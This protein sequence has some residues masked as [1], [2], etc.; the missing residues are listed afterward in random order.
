MKHLRRILY[1]AVYIWTMWSIL[2]IPA[3]SAEP[4]NIKPD[5]NIPAETGWII[6]QW[7]PPEGNP[8]KHL[9]LISDLH[10]NSAAQKSHQRILDILTQN[11]EITSVL[12]EGASGRCLTERYRTFEASHREFLIQRFVQLGL[13]T[14][15]EAWAIQSQHD[16]D[17]LGI[18]NPDTYLNHLDVSRRLAGIPQSVFETLDKWIASLKERRNHLYPEEALELSRL[19]E[20]YSRQGDQ[21]DLERL[22][23]LLSLQLAKKAPNIPQYAVIQHAAR[24]F[25]LNA[26]VDKE[27]ALA[28][29]RLVMRKLHPLLS[30]DQKQILKREL[31]TAKNSGMSIHRVLF[32]TAQ[33][34]GLDLTNFPN[35]IEYLDAAHQAQR[36]DTKALTSALKSVDELIEKILLPPG[37]PKQL[38]RTLR[39]TQTLR[40]M[41]GMAASRNATQR[42]R[43]D[44][45]E[46]WPHA[47][48]DALERLSDIE[49]SATDKELIETAWQDAEIFYRLAYRRDVEMAHTAA[50]LSDRHSALILGG[51]HIDGLL[52]ILKEH[53]IAY[54]VI[55]P[56]VADFES[57]ERRYRSLLLGGKPTAEQVLSTKPHSALMLP[58]ATWFDPSGRNP[59]ATDTLN[60]YLKAGAQ[61]QGEPENQTREML[62][63]L[64]AAE[65]TPGGLAA[66][67]SAERPPVP[68]DLV[69]ETLRQWR[70]M[71]PYEKPQRDRATLSNAN[72]VQYYFHDFME[73]TEL[74][75]IDNA[76]EMIRQLGFDA[77]WFNPFFET[78]R[79]YD[80]GGY[81]ISNYVNFHPDLLAKYGEDLL[82]S[83]LKRLQASGIQIM[84][85]LVMNHTSAAHLWYQASANP[86]HP[87]YIQFK[88]HYVWESDPNRYQ[89]R[90]AIEK[91]SRHISQA[92][93]DHLKKSGLLTPDLFNP[94]YLVWFQAPQ[95]HPGFSE[96]LT[97]SGFNNKEVAH[98][99]RLYIM[100]RM[101]SPG[102]T[103][104]ME[105]AS[106][107]DT[108]E[109]RE[110]II[111]QLR[112]TGLLVEEAPVN[113]G[114][115]TLRVNNPEG[116]AEK[117]AIL[118]NANIV[119]PQT[120]RQILEIWSLSR[121]HTKIIFS[122][123]EPSNWS[124]HPLRSALRIIW[125][126]YLHHLRN[127]TTERSEFLRRYGL[128]D[129]DEYI[130]TQIREV[131]ALL[132]AELNQSHIWDQG[133]PMTDTEV[134]AR[135]D[136]LLQI[137]W[138]QV[139]IAD[140]IPEANA[141]T[142]S[143]DRKW[144]NQNEADIIEPL[145]S[146]II[147]L[148][149]NP[150][151]IYY[152]H[153]FFA[154]QP[155]LNFNHTQV[156]QSF[157]QIVRHWMDR[158]VY[159][160]RLDAFPYLFERE[161][162]LNEGLPETVAAL[163]D[164]IE[165]L[166][167]LPNGEFVETLLE[168]NQ[169]LRQL[170]AYMSANGKVYVYNFPAMSTLYMTA[171]GIHAPESAWEAQPQLKPLM[172]RAFYN[173]MAASIQQLQSNGH[174]GRSAMFL[175]LH[176]ETTFELESVPIRQWMWHNVGRDIDVRVN[177][178]DAQI[179]T[180]SNSQGIAD[181]LEGLATQI[182]GPEH[183]QAFMRV[184]I[185][186]LGAHQGSSVTYY[187]ML[188]GNPPG[189]QRVVE[190]LERWKSDRIEQLR[191]ENRRLPSPRT[192]MEL[193][194]IAE[195]ELQE[196]L[197]KQQLD[198]RLLNRG[199]IL[200]HRLLAQALDADSILNWH[201]RLNRARQ[202]FTGLT[203]GTD[204][205]LPYAGPNVYGVVRTHQTPAGH[206]Q[207]LLIHNLGPKNSRVSLSEEFL[208]QLPEDSP[209]RNRESGEVVLQPIVS[210]HETPLRFTGSGDIEIELPAYSVQWFSVA[211]L[212]AGIH[213]PPFSDQVRDETLIEASP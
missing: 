152:W 175:R 182:A 192:D 159:F 154:Y 8:D 11:Y 156:L 82:T 181:T 88:D 196:K 211:H 3:I 66:V 43:S 33:T 15:A 138:S 2:P 61:L 29:S 205:L 71:F 164:F 157:V 89:G 191:Q 187:H 37:E 77:I 30:A 171:A 99:T 23:R 125:L 9:Y 190:T 200:I 25:E 14:G 97:A 124:V 110:R 130:G 128:E 135:I 160:Y 108:P 167:A 103:V 120:M 145:R 91:L 57:S 17:L 195:K 10:A 70:Q 149:Y 96:Q 74:V 153:R 141:E 22:V 64:A 58:L 210:S 199:P 95:D 178:F 208:N 73:L 102:N 142:V 148:D 62:N 28:E 203:K 101:A 84:L 13:L 179:S 45:L 183:A 55:Q 166:H 111:G 83:T 27:L 68:E 52:P 150:N 134:S 98:L 78:P 201:L 172:Q 163:R 197:A 188:T 63:H 209:L 161:G 50:N 87:D 60:L 105:T 86:L 194:Q 213:A 44:S 54:T 180:R 118:T 146:K 131:T 81:A 170:H 38:A 151:Q 35:W 162:T 34:A 202:A 39:N 46:N 40:D 47:I 79:R 67:Q 121:H 109:D 127:H 115:I 93:I 92:T 24:A 76:I 20:T 12:H 173:Q 80:D 207:F 184:L 49:P 5:L 155:D 41:I 158:G 100:A 114:T 198:K 69:R 174:S 132:R 59:A 137:P 129:T 16:A 212:G 119:N 107:A 4:E 133:R 7:T 185:G 147:G 85:D 26:S 189:I 65:T 112:E 177:G 104:P 51:F 48:W 204:R 122:S 140:L 106:L 1:L 31:A 72:M 139:E 206:E 18:E 21:N 6:E 75:G 168:A 193:E 169:R 19:A 116:F 53:R 136:S 165:R 42:L 186:V 126:R 143:L 144:L 36:L 32:E 90:V 113:N 94:A 176:D 123:L 117:L 56:N